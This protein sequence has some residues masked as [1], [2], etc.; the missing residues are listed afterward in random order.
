MVPHFYRSET[1]ENIKKSGFQLAG[2][3]HTRSMPD[4]YPI[5]TPNLHSKP[6][7]HVCH[8]EALASRYV[9]F[10]KRGFGIFQDFTETARLYM[11]QYAIVLI[12]GAP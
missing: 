6:K 3:N 10:A 1:C 4:S 9:F 2:A 11:P 8:K 7:T 5:H 12:I